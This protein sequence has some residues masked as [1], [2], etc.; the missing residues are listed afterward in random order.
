[1]SWH[2]L[3]AG[4]REARWR[5]R[6]GPRSAQRAVECAAARATATRGS[7]LR[8]ALEHR[9][10]ILPRC[11]APTSTGGSRVRSVCSP[12]QCRAPLAAAT[13][14]GQLQEHA[15][16]CKRWAAERG[17]WRWPPPAAA[18]ALCFPP[19]ARQLRVITCCIHSLL[20]QHLL[21][22]DQPWRRHA[23]RQAAHRATAR[24]APVRAG[25]G[26]DEWR[27]QWPVEQLLELLSC[28]LALAA[29]CSTFH[30]SHRL[31]SSRLAQYV[32]LP[33]LRDVWERPTTER[34]V[35]EPCFAAGALGACTSRLG[36]GQACK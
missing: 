28:A 30:L 27:R 22:A 19:A 16:R 6:P 21:L 18:A 11:Q 13:V 3:R 8:S 34:P 29:T 24:P 26:G 25:A 9:K 14:L 1:M 2:R 12:P 7:L 36:Q 10:I 33:L 35:L 17:F 4:G 23:A 32:H 15:R 31:G 20:F 5:R